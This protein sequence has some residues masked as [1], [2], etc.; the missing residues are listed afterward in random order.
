MSPQ[1]ARE[2]P[3][4]LRPFLKWAGGKR[5]LLHELHR[6]V[7]PR[8][9]AYHEPFLGSGAVFFDLWRRGAVTE[10]RC[11]LADINPDLIGCYSA[12]AADVKAVI[13]ELSRL[14][15]RHAT[16]GAELYYRVR[17]T[18]FNP[19]R[20]ARS[21]V[22]TPDH[23]L[24]PADLAAMFIYL[25]RTGYNGL[26]RLNARGEFNV[27]A[28]RY[29][30]PRI[31]DEATLHA[32]AGVLGDPRVEIVHAPYTS[33]VTAARPGD[34]IY[35]D[36]PYAP[37][38]PTARFTSYTMASFSDGDQKD[39]HKMVLDLAARGCFV[40][41]SNSTAPLV[42]ALYDTPAARRAGLRAYRVAARRAINSHG[43]RRGEV[44]EFI[45]SNVAP[46]R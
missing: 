2:A 16:S 18:L 24:Y 8:F 20:M 37:L 33:V 23:G 29:A 3:P 19:R 39:L 41:L 10:C 6:F 17:D 40:V 4:R 11:R 5:Q 42:A 36:P 26:F 25:N 13:A 35:L 30:S 46:R 7:P 45:I 14:A 43:G 28:G 27:P 1:T 44:E 21:L 32:V 12:L 34:F 15:T 38:S 31:C 9:E 22:E